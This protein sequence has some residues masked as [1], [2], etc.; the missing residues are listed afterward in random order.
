MIGLAFTVHAPP[1]LLQEDPPPRD[2]DSEEL[3]EVVEPSQG[4]DD[5]DTDMKA[6]DVVDEPSPPAAPGIQLER[7]DPET[8]DVGGHVLNAESSAADLKSACRTL[9]IGATGSKSVLF[10][11]LVKHMQRKGG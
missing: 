4:G 9:G 1:P 3:P 11:R 10:K 2:G 6:G 5:K 8:L 7:R